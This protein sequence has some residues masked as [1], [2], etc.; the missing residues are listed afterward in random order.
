MEAHQI[1]LLASKQ[2]QIRLGSSGIELGLSTS[3]S[4]TL[5]R[6][7]QS[8]ETLGLSPWAFSSGLRTSPVS[9]NWAQKLISLR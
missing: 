6:I 4:G 2:S 9:W 8:T 1:I 3:F 5:L 7:H